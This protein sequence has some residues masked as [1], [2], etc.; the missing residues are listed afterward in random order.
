MICPADTPE[1]ES[2]GL[3]KNLSLVSHITTDS[4]EE[5]ALDCQLS[6]PKFRLFSPFCAFSSTA[7]CRTFIRSSSTSSTTSLLGRGIFIVDVL[8]TL[9]HHHIVF[10]NGSIAGVTDDV[11]LIIR[12]IRTMRRKG[13]LDPFVSVS[14]N[15][16]TNALYLASDGGQIIAI[17]LCL[18]NLSK[19]KKII[20]R[21]DLHIIEDR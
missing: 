15:T 13:V 18:K 6:C 17:L 21:V 12:T 10:L 14:F 11:E 16:S 19:F 1:G 2:C 8:L 3:V 20:H 4:D 5:V 9:R 7:A